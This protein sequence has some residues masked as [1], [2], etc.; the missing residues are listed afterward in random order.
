MSIAGN[1]DRSDTGG[2]KQRKTITPE[3][4][5]D[6]IR[7]Y[8]LNESTVDIVNATGI[9]EPTLRTLRKQ[10]IKLRKTVKVQ[11]G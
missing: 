3:E 7:R 9:P 8:E 5:L 4:K 2:K 1:S 6:V 10:V 11:R